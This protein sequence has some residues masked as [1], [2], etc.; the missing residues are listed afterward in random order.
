[1]ASGLPVVVSKLS[2]AAELIDDEKDGMKI[3]D[4]T[5]SDEIAE[6]LNYLIKNDIVR[7]EMGRKAR[8]KAEEFTWE[9]AAEQMLEV[10]E[11]S[12]RQ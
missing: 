2:G 7:K 11:K 8:E 1:M 9:K 5:N 10:F 3:E 6:K 4:P 12:S